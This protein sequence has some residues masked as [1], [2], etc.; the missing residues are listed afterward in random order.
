MGFRAW[1]RGLIAGALLAAFAGCLTAA[2]QEPDAQRFEREY[3]MLRQES[4]DGIERQLSIARAQSAIVGAALLCLLYAIRASKERTSRQPTALR[5][6]IWAVLALLAV[7]SFYRFSFTDRVRHD[8]HIKDV[9]H[10]FIGGKYAAE[11]GYGRIY[12][13]TLKVA[14]EQRRW[15]VHHVEGV[16]ELQTM[17]TQPTGAALNR[18]QSECRPRFSEARWAAFH[19][20]LGW[21]FDRVEGPVWR[22]TLNDFGY[23]PSPVW[24]LLAQPF[25]R[26]AG[27]E[28]LPWLVHIDALLVLMGLGALGWAFGFEVMGLAAI[29]WG[30]GFLWRYTWVGDAFL[31]QIWFA[32]ALIG[33]ACLARGRSFVAGVALAVS[34]GVRL[35]PAIFALGYAAHAGRRFWAERRRDHSVIAFASGLLLVGTGLALA[36]LVAAGEGLQSALDFAHNTAALRDVPARNMAGLPALLWRIDGTTALQWQDASGSFWFSPGVSQWIRFGAICVSIGLFGL[37]LRGSQPWESAALGFALI[38]LWV[39]PT[40][41]YFHFVVLAAPLALRRPWIGVWLLLACLA[42]LA[43]G[44]AW[45]PLGSQF[46]AASWIAVVL[47]VGV[48]LAMLRPAKREVP[49]DGTATLGADA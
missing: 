31:R 14:V 4:E 30:T 2:A 44:L 34:A 20:D 5:T 21:F 13:C 41:Y 12:D 40:G 16:R 17:T 25:T 37:T 3:Q 9:Y 47:S 36:G 26:F 32:S 23:N 29:A 27:A 10:Y 1:R 46:T 18:A 6:T 45:R 7:A 8:M 24:T 28:A 39:A 22:R 43:N 42:W 33:V 15:W 19:R 11:L 38:P 35:F 48:L 49:S